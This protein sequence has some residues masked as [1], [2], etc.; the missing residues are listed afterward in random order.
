VSRSAA[1]P[2]GG[3]AAP[4]GPRARVARLCPFEVGVVA[5]RSPEPTL[6]LV[7]K[8]TFSLAEGG[9]A[10]VA[11]EQE[12]LSLDRPALHGGEGE[13][14]RASDFAPLKARVDVFLT[15]HARAGTPMHVLPAGF[16]VDGLR[17]RFYAASDAPSAETPLLA[18]YLR[19]AADEP[20]SVGPSAVWSRDPDLCTR[21]GVPSAELGRGFD[22]G[23]FN[24]APADQQID[25]L[26]PTARLVLDGLFPGGERR[27]ARLPGVR[28]RVFV[29]PKNIPSAGRPP[30]EIVLRCD[31]LWIDVDRALCTLTFRGVLTT[32]AVSTPPSLVVALDAG[33]R[34]KTWAKALADLDEVDFTPVIAPEDLRA[35]ADAD[36]ETSRSEEL[37]VLD[38][39]EIEPLDEEPSTS[40]NGAG[41][42]RRERPDIG[43]IPGADDDEAT[44]V[45]GEPADLASRTMEFQVPDHLKGDLA[46]PLPFRPPL[47]VLGGRRPLASFDEEDE[48][49]NREGLPFTAPAGSKRAPATMPPP[50]PIAP[51][52]LSGLPFKTADLPVLPPPIARPNAPP[53]PRLGTAVLPFIPP[54]Q[55]RPAEDD[56]HWSVAKAPPRTVGETFAQTG[57]TSPAAASRPAEPLV[58]DPP[59]PPPAALIP[60]ADYAAVKAEIWGDLDTLTGVLQRHSIDEA[61]W[62]ANERR[63]AEALS[64]EANEGRSTLASELREALRSARDQRPPDGERPLRSLEDAYIALLAAID[65]A[66]DPAAFIAS[67]G[68][69]PAEWRRL[70]RRFLERAQNDARAGE[71]L[72]AKLAEARRA[73]GGGGA[74]NLRRVRKE[75]APPG[76]KRV[77]A[78]PKG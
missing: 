27:N 39:A 25:L 16:A 61:A 70:R 48:S 54:K 28:P 13:L 20:V 78:R 52:D 53:P 58:K 43:P 14:S 17:K 66:E 5:W 49:P 26:A 41:S 71:S 1:Q 62:H 42:A 60:I 75:P 10:T 23:A 57:D 11:A 6:T 36:P 15:G 18:A 37:E 64:K 67:Q 56:A 68:L 63:L 7:V 77:P 47:M 59:R 2:R 4:A 29:V 51:R 19:S 40:R 31:T 34:Q 8:A 74:L 35:A 76:A 55:A 21:D 3:S 45:T 73:M 38:E 44:G 72:A 12:P 50:A 9:A 65:G 69:S 30:E 33:D 22:Y 32:G 46:A 24:V